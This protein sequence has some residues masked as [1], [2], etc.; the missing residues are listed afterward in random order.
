MKIKIQ[1]IYRGVII[2]GIEVFVKIQKYAKV[3]IV[4]II[5]NYIF[6]MTYICRYCKQN[7]IDFGHNCKEKIENENINWTG[8]IRRRERK[9]IYPKMSKWEENHLKKMRFKKKIKKK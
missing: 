6:K 2:I 3:D 1:S 5:K 8:H 4:N 7:I 9:H